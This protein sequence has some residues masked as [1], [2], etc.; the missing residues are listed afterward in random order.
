M[1]KIKNK[2]PKFCI[3]V[4]ASDAKPYNIRNK[5]DGQLESIKEF[6]KKNNIV[7][8]KVMRKADMGNNILKNFFLYIIEE[9]RKKHIDGVVCINMD[10]VSVSLSDAYSK[11]AKVIEAGG[12]VY[13]VENGELSLGI[14][15]RNRIGGNI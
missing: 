13:T 14:S 5:E 1:K 8:T 10:V 3:A 4:L 2:E 11:V 9:T 12:H 6:S 7:I 15:V